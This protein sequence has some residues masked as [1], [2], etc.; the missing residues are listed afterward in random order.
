MVVESFATA[1]ASVSCPDPDGT[2]TRM[3]ALEDVHHNRG[4]VTNGR[5]IDSMTCDATS[6]VSI[7][8]RPT[9]SA[10]AIEGMMASSRVNSLRTN[11]CGNSDFSF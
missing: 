4:N 9:A 5:A 1:S 2:L 6:S 10:T 8:S 7:P 3:M 11:G